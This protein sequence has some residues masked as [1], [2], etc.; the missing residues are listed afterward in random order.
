MSKSNPRV[1]EMIKSERAKLRS[2][3]KT[4]R[5]L[6]NEQNAN[7]DLWRWL[8]SAAY[9]LDETV[10]VLHSALHAFEEKNQ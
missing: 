9:H 6:A 10:L 5:K 1:S 3:A 8:N 7:S 2:R 4:F